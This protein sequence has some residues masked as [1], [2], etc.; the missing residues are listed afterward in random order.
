MKQGLPEKLAPLAKP[1]L[2]G[3]QGLP[4]KLA[5]LALLGQL[6]LPGKLAPLVKPALLGQLGL[7]VKL[8]ILALLVFPVILVK[9]GPQG[10]LALRERL[11]RRGLRV[12]LARLA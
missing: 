8:A 7:P 9:Q 6:A 10:Q 11:A 5:P 2:L 4:G 3:K 1:A 12:Q